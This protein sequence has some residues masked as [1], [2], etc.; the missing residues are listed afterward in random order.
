MILAIQMFSAEH[1]GKVVV[2]IIYSVA[3]N[4]TDDFL[5]FIINTPAARFFF[6]FQTIHR[7]MLSTN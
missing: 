6:K 7:N 3:F 2:R 4:S 5:K 1:K